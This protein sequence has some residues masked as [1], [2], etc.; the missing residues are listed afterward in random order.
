[1]AV[2]AFLLTWMLLRALPPLP[3]GAGAAP[4]AIA[5]GFLLNLALLGL[6][7]ARLPLEPMV[8]WAWLSVWLRCAEW[9]VAGALGLL[10]AP[11]SGV[12]LKTAVALAAVTAA[13]AALWC[14]I[15]AL[16]GLATRRRRSLGQMLTALLFAFAVAGLFWSRPPLYALQRS[17]PDVYEPA[18]QAVVWLGPVTGVAAVFSEDPSGFNLVKARQTYEVWLGANFLAYPPLWPGRSEVSGEGFRLG[19]VLTLSLWGLGL[20]VACEALGLARR[21]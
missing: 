20:C 17:H 6:L 9:S 15:S 7:L 12:T 8:P 1:V 10:A 14:G 2:V 21:G 5:A 4:G 11:G 16:L 3:S 19:L 18:T 13:Q